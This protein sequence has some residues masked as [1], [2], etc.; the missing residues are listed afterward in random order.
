MITAQDIFNYLKNNTDGYNNNNSEYLDFGNYDS[1]HIDD[2]EKILDRY[3]DM[4]DEINNFIDSEDLDD[5]FDYEK[6]IENFP[7]YKDFFE[8]NQA[9][10]IEEYEFALKVYKEYF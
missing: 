6:I 9:V 1:L 2:C 7:E 8:R 10:L 5:I 3:H 4:Q